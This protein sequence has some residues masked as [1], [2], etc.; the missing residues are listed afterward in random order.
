[1]QSFTENSRSPRSIS[2]PFEEFS[3]VAIV[4]AA[5]GPWSSGSESLLVS[6]PKAGLGCTNLSALRTLFGVKEVQKKGLFLNR[7]LIAIMSSGNGARGLIKGRS[8]GNLRNSGIQLSSTDASSTRTKKKNFLHELKLEVNPFT[9]DM[10][11]RGTSMYVSVSLMI[12]NRRSA[13]K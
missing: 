11:F 5:L 13:L 6:P 2:F 1:M 4:G 7:S 10:K 8:F 9:T 3:P 12:C